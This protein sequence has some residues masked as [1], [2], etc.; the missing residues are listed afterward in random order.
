MPL[1][2][3]RLTNF[4]KRTSGRVKSGNR[5]IPRCVNK[6]KA[7]ELEII[8]Y[9]DVNKNATTPFSRSK[10]HKGIFCASE[11]DVDNGDLIFDRADQDYYFV[12]DKKMR[13]YNT[14][15]V[16]I[17]ATMYRCD[18]VLDI[19]RFEQG[20]RD[21][22]GRVVQDAPMLVEGKAGLRA[23]FNPQ[24][25]DVKEQQD[26]VIPENKIKIC[27]H[28]DSEVKV[29]DRLVTDKGK[30]Y[31]VISIDEESLNNLVLCIVDVD[32]R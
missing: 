24:N 8:G 10:V 5:K 29:A 12:M 14:E 27:L 28:A 16:Y 17:D 31:Q 23:M 22:F 15:E 20:V 6:S 11:A 25:Y 1:I 13:M 4:I 7:P 21:T 9:I 26:R 32:V 2:K 18:V 30:K 19:Y 3:R